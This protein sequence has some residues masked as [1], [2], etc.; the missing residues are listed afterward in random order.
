MK[1][2]FFT[3]W[4]LLW[5]MGRISPAE[6]VSES[7]APSPPTSTLAQCVAIAIEH[8]ADLG[9]ASTQF[10]AARGVAVK[11][12]AILY[13][14]MTTQ[15][16]STPLL[17]YIQIQEIFYSHGTLPQLRI[18]R[19][20]KDE[21]MIN[22]RQTLSDVVF[23][24]RQAYLI[25]LVAR[26]Q[27]ELLQKLWESKVSGAKAAQQLFEG[28]QLPKS[29]VIYMQVQG[30]LAKQNLASLDL[31]STQARLSL[32]TIMGESLPES[33]R[34]TGEFATEAPPNLDVKDLTETA[35]RDREDLKMLES[36][37]L[38][39]EQQIAVDMKAVYPQAGFVSD[40]AFQAPAL[41]YDKNFDAQVNYNEPATERKAGNTQLPLSLYAN[42]QIFDGG[43]AIGQK[44]SDKAAMVSR[45]VAMAELRQSISTEVA[46]AVADIISGRDRLKEL[47]AEPAPEDLRQLSELEFQAGRLR[48]IDKFNLENDI[49]Q[50]EQSRLLS[51]YELSAATAA[52]DHALGRDVFSKDDET[53]VKTEAVR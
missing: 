7:S 1:R 30:D 40:S 23:Q 48:Q 45:D 16:L 27:E 38:S 6:A 52:L 33:A 46:R 5:L 22:Y 13:P 41:A 26:K 2:A 8:N 10:L 31:S 29:A 25:A 44:K 50:Q 49:Y 14:T 20:T 11:L 37:Q 28:G 36:L 19:L 32:E 43:A 47:N 53:G 9:R 15:V 34:L 3:W 12:H 4:L 42:W 39:A 24:V 18:S 35:L 17:M 21:A 51:E